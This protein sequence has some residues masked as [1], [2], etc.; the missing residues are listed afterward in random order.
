MASTLAGI[1]QWPI[2]VILNWICVMVPAVLGNCVH[3][4][5]V[6]SSSRHSGIAAVYR[7]LNIPTVTAGYH[8]DHLRLNCTSLIVH[9]ARR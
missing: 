5:L 3:T 4:P 6:R 2:W 9:A 7:C 1:K 8:A